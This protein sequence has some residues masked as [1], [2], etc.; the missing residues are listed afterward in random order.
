M[1][2]F[3]AKVRPKSKQQKVEQ[4]KNCFIVWVKAQARDG[5]AT[6][7]AKFLLENYL[8]KKNMPNKRR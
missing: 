1:A 6:A 3:R 2:I 8:G 7:E 5:Q 4:G